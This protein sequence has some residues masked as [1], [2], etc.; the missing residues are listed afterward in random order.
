MNHNEDDSMLKLLTVISVLLER[1]GGRLEMTEDELDTHT[2]RI[3]RGHVHGI[4]AER[5]GEKWV[6]REA[7]ERDHKLA[8]ADMLRELA[9]M[10]PR[11]EAPE[12]QGQ[13]VEEPM[14]QGFT[15]EDEKALR[16]MGFKL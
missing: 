8:V 6:V 13:A 14:L 16:G 5:V 4:L 2:R 1:N 3:V 9:G 11:E 15:V 12:A 7:S 10:P